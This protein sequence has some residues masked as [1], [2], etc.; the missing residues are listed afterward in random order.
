ERQRTGRAADGDASHAQSPVC[1]RLYRKYHRAPRCAGTRHRVPAQTV[2]AVRAVAEGARSPGYG[3]RLPC[4]TEGTRNME[5]NET[6]IESQEIFKGK[7]VHLRVDS[8]RVPDGSESKR[9]IVA[10]KGAVCIVPIREDGRILL[11][12]QFRL[13]A[14]K[15]LLEIPAG[16][17][18]EN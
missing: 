7:I 16:T 15:V 10:H 1:F 17:R 18:E 14:G 8:V 2:H 3:R 9:E 6:V 5:W 13:A 11:V 12:K 4:E